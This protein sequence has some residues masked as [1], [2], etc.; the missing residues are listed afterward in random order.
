MTNWDRFG[1]TDG[2]MREFSSNFHGGPEDKTGKS[3][4]RIGDPA[5]KLT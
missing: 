2:V 5:E 1:S 3:S 4:T